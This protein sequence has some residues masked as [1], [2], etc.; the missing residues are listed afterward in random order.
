[1]CRPLHRFALLLALAAAAP[2]GCDGGEVAEIE[3]EAAVSEVIPTVVTVRLAAELDGIDA[4]FV[5][6]GP[7][8]TYG[9]RVRAA[10]Q[11]D[12]WFEATL[13]GSPASS[14][15]HLRAL[16]AVGDVEVV[17]EDHVVETGAQPVVLPG[18]S[19]SGAHPHMS[20]GGFLVTSVMA[21]PTMAVILDDLGRYVWWYGND[22]DEADDWPITRARLSR[23]GTSALILHNV[24]LGDDTL[25]EE[26]Y[27]LEIALDG[28]ASERIP[29]HYAHNDF[30]E[31]P[32]GT[33]A[34]LAED[35]REVDG[36]LVYGDRIVEIQPDGSQVEV[37]SVWDDL[38][39]DPDHDLAKLGYWTHANA[40][41]YDEVH[42]QYYVGARHVHAIFKVD[43]A[44]GDLVWV[45][46][47]S[48][49]DFEL[50]VGEPTALQHQFQV[51]DGG[52]LVFDNGDDPDAG[53]RAVEY[54]LDEAAGEAEVVWEYTSDPLVYCFGM[55]DVTR[56]ETGNTLVTW[57]TSGMIDE[58]SPD[59]ELLWRVRLEMGGGLAYM[60]PVPS[61]YAR[62]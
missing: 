13:L 59:D 48:D 31:L 27:I 18:T 5:D 35:A 3:V 9:T 37:W 38:E 34:F 14:E 62:P 60:T 10:D 11:G 40:L 23:D 42:D 53:S 50:L 26:Q 51:L 8:E 32:D 29:A 7:T 46:G 30:V 33:I 16:L 4:A 19:R 44:T 45:F 28:S 39:Y 25:P 41:D 55:G 15:V 2:A 36:E 57:S 61:L 24:P 47:G 49:S 54:E 17:G 43:R 12:G 1:M 6:F 20:A 52:L 56:M 22:D 21:I 58:V